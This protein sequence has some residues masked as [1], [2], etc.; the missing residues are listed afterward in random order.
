MTD[1]GVS[2]Q[3]DSYGRGAGKP[4]GCSSDEEYDAGL[5][6]PPCEHGADGEGP[7]CW[8]HCPVG[9]TSCAGTL[10][11]EDGQTCTE[12]YVNVIQDS[13]SAVIEIAEDGISGD[14]VIDLSKIV[15]DFSYPECAD[16]Y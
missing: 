3:K 9:T 13:L 10:C 16:W 5:C 8:G 2:C 14:A 4:L 15:L 1:I 6:Y 7:V 11:L 12:N